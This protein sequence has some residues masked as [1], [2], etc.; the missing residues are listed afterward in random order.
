VVSG[1]PQGSVLGP[2]LFS[3]SINDT[4]SETECT[5]SKFANDTKLSSVVNMPEGW[6]AIQRDLDELEKCACVNLMRLNKAKCKV[7]HLGQGN[8]CYQYRLQDE[9]LECSPKEKDLGVQVDEKLDTTQQYA[10]AAQKANRILGC[11]PSSVASR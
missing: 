8:P 10:L 9:G 4:D 2:V 1:V 11:S 7:L 6:D 5:L 3:I